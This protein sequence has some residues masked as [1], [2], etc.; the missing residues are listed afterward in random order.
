MPEQLFAELDSGHRVV[1]TVFMQ[2][3]WNHRQTG[4][5]ALRPAGETEAVNATAVLSA[6]GAYGPARACHGIVAW[7][8]LR[9][10][11]LDATLDAHMQV[12]PERFRGIRQIAASRHPPD[13]GTRPGGHFHLQHPNRARPAARPRISARPGSARRTRTQLR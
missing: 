9:S 7:A 3:G 10:P 11:E 1:A 5:E 6:T 2:C 4:P 13:R 8:D 12:A